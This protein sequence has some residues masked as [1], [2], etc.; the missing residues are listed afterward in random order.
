M[1]V[2]VAIP[3]Y[4][5]P[6]DPSSPIAG[7]ST[8]EDTSPQIVDVVDIR[9]SKASFTLDNNGF[10]IARHD[11]ILSRSP[12]T[13]S[14]WTNQKIREEVYDPEIAE[15][16]KA[17]TGAKKVIILLASARNAPFKEAESAPPYPQPSSSEEDTSR[18]NPSS[19]VKAKVLP[20]QPLTTR[21]KG[22]A[23]GIREGPV[24]KPHKDWGTLGARN[25]L[26]NWS[27]D[28]RTEAQDIIE[29]EDETE[30]LPGGITKN[31]QGRRWALYTTW[32]P[33]KPV[34]RDPMGYVD[35]FSSTENDGVSFWRSP[36]GINGPF[37]SDVVLTKA[38]PQHRWYW[39]SDQT[40]DEVLFMKI[41]DTESEKELSS[42][43]GGV[44]HFSFHI[45]G[46]EQEEVRESLET[47]FIAFW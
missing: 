3:Y 13:A 10:Q 12:Y 41:F 26:R 5:G 7:V 30:S 35:Y 1:S 20:E 44:H 29:A 39:L 28:L 24:R 43:A 17:V 38:N 6:L 32:R 37:R 9:P 36:P 16:A 4:D 46:T 21:G 40:P 8:I 14:S 42:V 47:K 27:H 25:T 34:R 23:D 22:F 45:P 18:S 11:S 19:Q 31:Y 15:L 33:L 2:K